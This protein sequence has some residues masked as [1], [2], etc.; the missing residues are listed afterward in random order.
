MRGRQH[1][2]FWIFSSLFPQGRSRGTCTDPGKSAILLLCEGTRGDLFTLPNIALERGDH[3][4]IDRFSM[5]SA[6]YTRAAYI[7]SVYTSREIFNDSSRLCTAHHDT[8]VRYTS[9]IFF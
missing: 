1:S 9:I 7:L 5:S 6:G 8:F 4:A 2:P 3:E